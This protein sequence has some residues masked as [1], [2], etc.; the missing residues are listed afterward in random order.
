MQEYHAI[1]RHILRHGVAS[2]SRA[3]LRSTGKP[4]GTIAV[5]G[6]QARFDLTETF[7]AVTGKKL[8]WK[9]VVGEMLWF[10]SG[11]TNV[12]PLQAQGIHI[13]D[14]WADEAGEL[15]PVYGAQWRAWGGDP[16]LDQIKTL[17]DGIRKD[18][19][20]RRHI[21][22]A[23]N[24]A[25]VPKMALPPCHLLTQFRVLRDKLYCMMTMRSN[26]A[27]LGLP[28]NIASYALLT[29]LVGRATGYTPGELIIS[30]GDLHIY[31]NHLPAVEEYLSRAPYPL[32]TLQL[33]DKTDIDTWT[34]QDI[35][36]VGYRSHPAINAEIAV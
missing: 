22:N 23:W 35:Q 24:V 1:L 12:K 10:L 17:I 2:P 28:F 31:E 5:F 33:A 18:P 13:W 25:D 21:L 6:H 15:G 3:I 34:L 36:L 7:P 16:S 14:A 9:G 27:Y 11:S 26:D 19:F 30:F 29:H 32:P 8:F 20:G 4:V